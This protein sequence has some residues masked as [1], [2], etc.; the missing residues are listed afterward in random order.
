LSHCKAERFTVVIVGRSDVI[1]RDQGEYSMKQVEQIR[2]LSVLRSE[3]RKHG[4]NY[5]K[6][7]FAAE[8]NLLPDSTWED[9]FR[10]LHRV[11]KTALEAAMSVPPVGQKVAET[12][13]Q[14]QALPSEDPYQN[15]PF[16]RQSQ[17]KSNLAT[18]TVS[19]ETLQNPTVK[20]LYE[21]LKLVKNL[22]VLGTSYRLSEYQGREY[23][24]KWSA[25]TIA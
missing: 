23:L 7:E 20:D 14:P 4:D 1:G 12:P 8:D 5:V 17:K 2:R 24:Q 16:W 3:T 6:I 19:P 18:F 21:K 13:A 22:K 11:V 15:L 10:N 9:G 25:F